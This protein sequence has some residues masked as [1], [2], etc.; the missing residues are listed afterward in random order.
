MVPIA[1]DRTGPQ[2]PYDSSPRP[3]DPDY[4]RPERRQ[5]AID[6]RDTVLSVAEAAEPGRT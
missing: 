4:R 2:R 1:P 5:A 3:A 6:P